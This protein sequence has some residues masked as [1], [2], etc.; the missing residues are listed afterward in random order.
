[1]A[2]LFPALEGSPGHCQQ[3]NPAASPNNGS[4]PVYQPLIL[5]VVRIQIATE[6][7]VS[8]SL[9]HRLV[10]VMRNTVNQLANND[11]LQDISGFVFH[12]C[13]RLQI[14]MSTRVL[15]ELRVLQN[16]TV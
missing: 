1:L 3:Q 2:N 5:P 7:T 9:F 13:I 10:A 4:D 16:T 14:A 12:F 11:H 6:T 15:Q 8:G